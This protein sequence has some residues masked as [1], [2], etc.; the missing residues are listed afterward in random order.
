MALQKNNEWYT[1]AKYIEAAR[2]VMGSIDL[3]PASCAKANETVR[4]TAYYTKEQDGLLKDWHGNVWLNP[5]YG[6]LEPEKTGSTR[7]YQQFFMQK[8]LI[9]YQQGTVHQAIALLLGNAY[10]TRWFRPFCSYPLCFYSGTIDFERDTGE[11]SHFGF[12][13]IFVYLGPQRQRFV[14]MFSQFGDVFGRL[15][16]SPSTSPISQLSLSLS[17]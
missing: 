8:L 14:D 5:P 3:D 17:S 7:S 15:T 4:A 12:G 2:Q 10:F 9:S 13:T 11:R 6:R 16:P 1:P